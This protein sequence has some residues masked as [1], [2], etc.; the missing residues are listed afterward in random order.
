MQ[1]TLVEVDR[2]IWDNPH[3][4]SLQPPIPTQNPHQII[5][6]KQNNSFLKKTI[7]NTFSL[8][9]V[10]HLF[11]ISTFFSIFH[12]FHFSGEWENHDFSQKIMI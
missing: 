5:S 9:F 8:S 10:S 7:S 3:P 1:S 2:G 12:Q 11:Q 4:T 6:K